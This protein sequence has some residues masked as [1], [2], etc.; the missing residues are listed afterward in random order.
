MSVE[1]TESKA[2][3]VLFIPRPADRPER[4]IQYI[5]PY[6]CQC[7]SSSERLP[8]LL[9]HPWAQTNQ[10]WHMNYW[11]GGKSNRGDRDL[12]CILNRSQGQQVQKTHFRLWGENG[13]G[14]ISP[15]LSMIIKYASHILTSGTPNHSTWHQHLTREGGKRIMVT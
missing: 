8:S 13:R 2:F 10:T 5:A 3:L 4:G 14:E 12:I 15:N 7:V 1:C 11:D 6:V 9:G